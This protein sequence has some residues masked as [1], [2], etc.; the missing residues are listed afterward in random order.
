MIPP[1]KHENETERLQELNSFSILDTLPEKDYDDITRIASEICNTKISLISFIDEDRQW[2]KS[3][4]GYVASQTSRDKAFC[5][6]AINGQDDLFIV[7]DA[8][9]DKRFCD[10][11]MV[12]GHP[13]I[14]FYAGVPLKSDKGLPLGTLCVVDNEAKSL[15]DSQKK[16]LQALANQVMNIL[17]LRKTKITL[18]NTTTALA[19]KNLELE[20]FASVAAHDLK[21][22][23]ISISEMTR[24]VLYEYGPKLDN[25]GRDMMALIMDST[26]NLTSL[27]DG[28]LEYSK[29][30]KVLQEKKSKVNLSQLARKINVLFGHEEK[31][32]I[33]LNSKL[34]EIVTNSAALDRILINLVANAIK[35]NDKAQIEIEIGVNESEM[36]YEIYVK[37]NGPGISLKNQ[38]K[39]FQIFSVMT[40]KDRYG[41]TGNGIGLATVKKLVESSG[42]YINVKSYEGEGANFIFTLQK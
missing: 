15:S 25:E 13:N 21:S 36:A 2:L 3:S 9:E 8:R 27:V 30:E 22:P 26:K 24:L 4:H 11:P 12:T 20:R 1:S 5:A 18:E 17:D 7:Q 40:N 37:D 23:L 34:K 41:N 28:L 6:H 39:I 32:S 16:S 42:G 31:L 33:K 14:T 35:Y 38:E 10:N 19:H 29:S